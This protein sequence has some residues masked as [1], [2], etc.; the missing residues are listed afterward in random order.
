MEERLKVTLLL[1]IYEGLLTIKQRDIM[2]LYFND[3][4]SLAE[5]SEI[6]NT[7]RQAVFDAIKRCEKTLFEY[8][9]KL[10]ILLKNEEQNKV[11]AIILSKLNHIQESSE[12][13]DILETT[14]DIEKYLTELI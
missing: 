10:G 2:E 9:N 1:D 12:D 3:D 4:L 6:T 7:S 13:K 11:R 5:I 8:E 14:K